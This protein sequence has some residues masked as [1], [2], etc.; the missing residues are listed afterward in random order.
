MVGTPSRKT[1]DRSEVTIYENN[2]DLENSETRMIFSGGSVNYRKQDATTRTNDGET[3]ASGSRRAHQTVRS[4]R[5]RQQVSP[6]TPSNL[7]ARALG[8]RGANL[9][10][11]LV[12]SNEYATNM[13]SLVGSRDSIREYTGPNCVEIIRHS[14]PGVTLQNGSDII[15]LFQKLLY[16]EPVY[17]DMDK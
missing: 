3:T 6:T 15:I 13:S 11:V 1:E 4:L 9:T 12:Q 14:V 5:N 8:N 10:N 7:G 2:V 16:H 17:C